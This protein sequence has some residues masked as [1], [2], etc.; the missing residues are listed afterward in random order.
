MNHLPPDDETTT[1]S[2]FASQPGQTALAE[3]ARCGF[4]DIAQVTSGLLIVAVVVSPS[5]SYI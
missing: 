5:W 1:Q 4:D 2:P 3:A